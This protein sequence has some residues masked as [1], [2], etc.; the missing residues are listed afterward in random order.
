MLR[1]PAFQLLRPATVAEATRMLAELGPQA[2]PL[3][4]GTDLLPKMKR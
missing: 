3:A 4:G 2:A 1:L